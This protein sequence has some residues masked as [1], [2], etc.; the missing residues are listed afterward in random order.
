MK[1][2]RHCGQGAAAAL[3]AAR[4][5][6]REAAVVSVDDLPEGVLTADLAVAELEDVAPADLDVLPRQL[7]P[8]DRPLR[9]PAVTACPVAV[10][11]VLD[12]RDPVEPRLDPFPNPLPADQTAPS[13][14]GSP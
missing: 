13:R 7:G 3:G 10:V 12:V 9:Y 11:A 2:I 6:E 14:P 8:A 1:R 5:P 4:R